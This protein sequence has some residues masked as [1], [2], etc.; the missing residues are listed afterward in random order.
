MIGGIEAAQQDLNVM[1]ALKQA[2]ETLKEIKSHPAYMN[3]DK[4]E[5]LVDDIKDQEA[6]EEEI[7][8]MF[9]AL[10]NEEAEN[11]NAELDDL[12]NLEL[13]PADLNIPDAPQTQI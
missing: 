10:S 5:Q 9:G 12:M 2:N 1:K 6:Q 8:N 13:D 4:V 11:L 3:P 7:A